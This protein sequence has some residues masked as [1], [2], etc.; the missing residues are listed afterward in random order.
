MQKEVMVVGGG[1]AGCEAAWQLAERGIQVNLYEMRP[2]RMTPAHKTNGLAELVC[3]NSFKSQDSANAHG[4]LKQEMRALNSF[5]L[6]AAEKAKIPAGSALAVD[7]ELFSKEITEK[8]KDHPSIRLIRQ[9]VST[10]SADCYQIIATGPLTAPAL[11]QVL[12]QVIGSQDCYFYDAISP[13]VDAASINYES[14]F[15]ASRYQQGAGDYLNCPLN[16]EQYQ[17]FIKTL[18]SSD[19]YPLHTFEEPRYFEGCLPI[20]EMARRGEQSLAFGP[21]KPVGL[22]DPR[23]QRRPYAVVQLRAENHPATMYNLVGFQTR[24]RHG[25][26]KRIFSMIPGLE[27]AEYFRYGGIHRNTYIHSPKHLTPFLQL[28]KIPSVFI[29]GQLTGVEGYMESTAMGL[30]TGLYLSKLIRNQ[31]PEVP[32][33]TTAL[34]GLTRYLQEGGKNG[35]QPMNINFGLLPPLPDVPKHSQRQLL[36]KRAQQDLYEWKERMGD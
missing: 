33:A 2:Q 31:P 7:R 18:L 32:P 10:L 9:E 25:E 20:E 28:K 36:I 29:A 27:R 6:S 1:L 16:E 5:I 34:G 26:Q 3:S 8:I 21:M 14:V 19:Q 13:I 30:L 23:T 17:N 35:F 15:K 22:V 12:I 4:L 24:M 11:E